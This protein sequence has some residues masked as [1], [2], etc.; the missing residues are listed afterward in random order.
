MN[1]FVG[2]R[3]R[4]LLGPLDPAAHGPLVPE[5]DRRADLRR[6]LDTPTPAVTG[7]PGVDGRP[8]AD[9]RS[10]G[11][12]LR[13]RGLIMAG[14]AAAV[15]VVAA[16]VAYQVVP[17]PQ[18]AYA[19]TPPPLRY[20]RV[21]GGGPA[22]TALTTIAAKASA[23]PAAPQPGTHEHLVTLSWDLWTEIDGERVRNAVVVTRT[24]S[25]RGADNSGRVV[26]SYQ[27]PQF[28]AGSDRWSRLR[29]VPD[30]G[31]HR[32]DYAPGRFPAMWPAQPPADHLDTWLAIGHPAANGPAETLVAVT[33]LARERV[34][35]PA[36]RAAVL[37][38]VAGLP[39]LT[40]EGR[41]TDRAGRQGEGF[42]LVSDHSGLPTRY[43]LIV[44]P[45]T[46]VLLGYES[47]L[48]TTA[49]KLDVRVPAVIGYET[50]ATAEFSAAPA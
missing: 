32:T 14:A 30:G 28:P 47:M 11:T 40:Y 43:T 44:A 3:I 5:A 50:Y 20:A 49:G 27:E 24:E 16:V 7:R 38:V 13:R 18:P 48:T 8:G 45:E 12:A 23:A 15:L 34:L 46:G 26:V 17:V 1:M 25:W 10:G 2:R 22:A 33:D 6:I 4:H 41:V 42:S 36:T 19:A 39:G 35:T 37:R 29:G 21:D 31:T 9:G